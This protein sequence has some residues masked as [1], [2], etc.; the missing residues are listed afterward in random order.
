MRIESIRPQMAKSFWFGKTEVS[1]VE[2]MATMAQSPISAVSRNVLFQLPN[3][4]FGKLK[5]D[6]A[7]YHYYTGEMP[8]KIEQDKY[9]ITAQ[10]KC[11]IDNEDY[12]SA[13]TG[14]IELAN[15]C[16]K[17]GKHRDCFLL[18][19]GIRRLYAQ[20]PE[21]DKKEAWVKIYQYNDDMARFIEKDIADMK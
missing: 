18:E 2:N 10:V 13:I 9:A 6:L 1:K 3:I 20:L 4:S 11:D 5:E 15:I 17:Q 19:Q 21:A 14:K 12:L 16:R 7:D 8:S